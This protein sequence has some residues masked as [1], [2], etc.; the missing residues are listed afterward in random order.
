MV[1]LANR[2]HIRDWFALGCGLFG[3][4]E[5]LR[6]A[7]YA[8]GAFDI[9][10]GWYRPPTGPRLLGRYFT[11]SAI[12][13]LP[14]GFSEVQQSSRPFGIRTRRTTRCLIKTILK[15]QPPNQSNE[16]NVHILEYL[17]S[18]RHSTLPWPGFLTGDL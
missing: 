9:I 1:N 4:W 16:A 8:M 6:A 11:F 18:V 5:S 3:I 13:F 17:T 7:D 2:Q 15:R 14:S 12:F 10:T